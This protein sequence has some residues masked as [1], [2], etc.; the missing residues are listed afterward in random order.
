MLKLKLANQHE[1]LTL[2]NHADKRVD[3]ELERSV[4]VMTLRLQKHVKT[5]HLL[6][7]VLN[8]R[9]GNLRNNIVRENGRDGA[10]L[11][12]VVGIDAGAPYGKLHEYGYSGKV[13][14]PEHWRT[15]TKAFGRNLKA[16]KRVKVRAHTKSVNLPERSFMRTALRAL[17]P[18]IEEEFKRA[19]WRAVNGA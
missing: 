2:L 14:V 5:H 19:L 10:R 3:A 7:Q 8:R 12:G 17:Q 13:N 9:T 18:A 11:F 1:L 16:A 15:V 6:G 4:A